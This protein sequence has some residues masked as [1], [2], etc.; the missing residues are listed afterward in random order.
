[1]DELRSFSLDCCLIRPP[2]HARAAA[3]QPAAAAPA[4]WRHHWPVSAEGGSSSAHRHPI[5]SCCGSCSGRPTPSS[6]PLPLFVPPAL[7]PS[8][9]SPGPPPLRH[10]H[11]HVPAP[12]N[13]PATAGGARL[14]LPDHR[15]RTPAQPSFTAL[16]VPLNLS[17]PPPPPRL[18]VASQRPLL[19]TAAPLPPL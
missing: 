9:V 8:A 17:S 4:G 3:N 5:P 11:L 14:S 18:A 2:F 6:L 19:S 13:S 16:V 1:M 12:V 15:P 7:P 10:F